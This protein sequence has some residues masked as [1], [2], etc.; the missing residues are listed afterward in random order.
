M[1][2]PRD[3]LE[4]LMRGADRD[5]QR[6]DAGGGHVRGGLLGVGPL[7]RRRRAAFAADLA[8]LALHPHSGAWQRATTAAVASTFAVVAQRAR[9]EHHEPTPSATASSTSP[10]EVA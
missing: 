9:V 10:A 1:V 4:H 6:V 7:P 2:E 3:P 5:G 8:D